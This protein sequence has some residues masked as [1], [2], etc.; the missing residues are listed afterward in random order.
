M[1]FKFCSQFN[2][3]CFSLSCIFLLL[4]LNSEEN[5]NKNWLETIFFDQKLIQTVT[6]VSSVAQSFLVF[7][8]CCSLHVHACI[9]CLELH[10]SSY[11]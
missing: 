7:L 3:L 11:H 10:V 6:G 8:S 1:L 2:D 9:L 4:S 5:K